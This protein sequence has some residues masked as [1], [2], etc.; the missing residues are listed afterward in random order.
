MVIDSGGR[1]VEANNAVA[2]SVGHTSGQLRGQQLRD[3]VHSDDEAVVAQ[4]WEYLPGCGESRVECRLRRADG[5][6][7]WAELTMSTTRSAGDRTWFC[8][9]T[10]KDV[11]DAR[12]LRDQLKYRAEHDSLTG[13]SNRDHFQDSLEAM[14]RDAPADA[15]VG[16]C[17]VDL[18]SFKTVN[19]SYGHA[20]GDE[21]LVEIGRRLTS[22]L[23]TP[24]FL[25]A[26]TGGDEFAV[27]A[28]ASEVAE[29]GVLARR[30]NEAVRP[31]VV[32]DGHRLSVTCSV[33]AVV[34]RACDSSPA[35]LVSAGD[36]TLAWAKS[37]G[38]NR[39]ELFDPGR[40]THELTRS[41]L[42]AT[43][44]HALDDGEFGLL[45]QPIGDI[46]SG[47]LRGVEALVRW[48]HPR[49]GV[50][51]PKEFIG[52]AEDSGFIVALGRWVLE[53]SCR[54]AQAWDG[55]IEDAFISVN[56]SVRQ[57]RE[58]EIVYEV[59]EVL[60]R[61]GLE[62]SRLQL[63]LTESTFLGAADDAKASLLALSDLGV[64]LA[65]DDFGTGYSNLAYLRAMPARALKLAEPFVS[66]LDRSQTLSADWIL[67]DG[68]VDLAHRLGLTVTAEGVET[69]EQAAALR[70]I[71]AD[72]VQGHWFAQPMP[73][74]ALV[75][76]FGSRP[77]VAT[78]C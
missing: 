18:D 23:S 33:G 56:L 77:T 28:R 24:E 12:R 22:S 15:L 40:G 44:S 65:I 63:E 1:V 27:L 25:V 2:A 48:N 67:V 74:D 8:V 57:L 41:T 32:V 46:G 17:C 69:E 10:V 38:G 73:P 52:L 29:A 30:L 78:T 59:R 19:D 39:W 43:M 61:T 47:R 72:Y 71:N 50:L 16:L 49:F 76:Q 26:R 53:E 60:G 42:S 70:E 36:I 64:G 54:Q 62:P 66:A 21:I 6:V 37:G 34:M 51:S 55:A 35:E 4:K 68:I 13:L 11:T 31:P 58:P 3:L 75:A 9:V 7:V 14:F 20:V 45:F 5:R